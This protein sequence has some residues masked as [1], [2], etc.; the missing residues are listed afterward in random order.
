MDTSSVSQLLMLTHLAEHRRAAL[1]DFGLQHADELAELHAV[2][3]LLH[4]ELSSHLL[5]CRETN[6]SGYRPVTVQVPIVLQSL[7]GSD[8]VVHRPPLGLL[9]ECHLSVEKIEPT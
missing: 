7:P 6:T 1:G 9:L 5:T 4:E 8:V 3:E 2:V